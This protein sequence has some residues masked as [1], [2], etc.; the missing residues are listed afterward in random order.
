[1]VSQHHKI[2]NCNSR[3]WWVV[4]R[5][6]E[7]P[8]IRMITRKGFG[9]CYAFTHMNNIVMG[10]EPLKGTVNHIITNSNFAD[11]LAA[12][13]ERGYTVVH[14]RWQPKPRSLI[15]RPPLVTCASY[16][17]YTFGIPFF[18]ITPYQLYKK[19]IR[20]GGEEI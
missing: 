5:T 14:F 1:M 17:A 16:L 12:Q 8:K 4:F 18:G 2:S 6:A 20:M 15:A 10:I 7:D 9:H 11:M 3:S 13:K 19:I